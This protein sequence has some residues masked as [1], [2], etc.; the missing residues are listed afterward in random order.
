MSDFD[1]KFIQDQKDTILKI[2]QSIDDEILQL[3]VSSA[4]VSP[5]NSIGR[6]SR[7]D[8][9]GLKGINEKALE[10]LKLKKKRLNS[11]LKR[12]EDDE[13]GYCLLCEEAITINRLKAMPE[14]TNCI[15]CSI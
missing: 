9:I 6:L 12:I 15:D 2:L 5:D 7:M 3:K 11:A 13:Y 8:A 14:A 1:Q 10:N 4:P